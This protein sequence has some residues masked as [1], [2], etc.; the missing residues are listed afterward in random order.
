MTGTLTSPPMTLG[1]R[2]LHAGNDDNRPRGHQP[3]GLRQEAVNA[4]NA[5]VEKAIDG[6]AHHFRRHAR[7]FGD[8]K[9]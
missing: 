6:V 5:D 7:L 3:P 1:R 2:P 8:R 4:G 9:V